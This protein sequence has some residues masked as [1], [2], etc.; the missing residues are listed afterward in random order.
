[1]AEIKST[2]ITE[3]D[4]GNH[5]ELERNTEMNEGIKRA[6]QKAHTRKKKKKKKSHPD[7]S[8]CNIRILAH[9]PCRVTTAQP[10]F[11]NPGTKSTL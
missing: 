2:D 7:A 10:I 1:M 8:V 5:E 6:N 9:Q 11:N 3:T 4:R